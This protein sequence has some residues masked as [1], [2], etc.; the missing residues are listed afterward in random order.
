M[1]RVARVGEAGVVI[2]VSEANEVAP[3][4]PGDGV[5][6]DAADWRSPEEKEEGGRIFEIGAQ[7]DRVELRFGNGAIELSRIRRG[8]LG[9]AYARSGP[10]SRGAA[11]YRS[12]GAGGETARGCAGHGA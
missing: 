5:V 12:S 11:V 1:G 10:R 7:G 4:K 8:D 6:F 3:L 9:L 2:D